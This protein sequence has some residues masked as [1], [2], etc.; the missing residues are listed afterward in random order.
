MEI[1]YSSLIVYL[2]IGLFLNYYAAVRCIRLSS[3]FYWFN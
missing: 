2:C 3:F 1:D